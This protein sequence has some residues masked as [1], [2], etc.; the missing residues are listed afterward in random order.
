MERVLTTLFTVALFSTWHSHRCCLVNSDRLS[1]LQPSSQQGK[2]LG[3][4]GRGSNIWTSRKRP[5]PR[6]QSGLQLNGDDEFTRRWLSNKHLNYKQLQKN[7][8]HPSSLLLGTP[9]TTYNL[10]R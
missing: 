3:W 6:K 10:E 9:S 1:Q 7:T 8:A 5:H 2:A 4:R